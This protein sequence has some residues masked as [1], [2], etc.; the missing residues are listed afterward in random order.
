MLPLFQLKLYGL[1]PPATARL[2]LPVLQPK[3]LTERVEGV[4][5]YEATGCVIVA[6][7]VAV[8]EFTSNK[9]T[10]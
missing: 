9:V 2:I 8:H 7:F 1:V 5:L 4:A 3:Q 6:E 10:V